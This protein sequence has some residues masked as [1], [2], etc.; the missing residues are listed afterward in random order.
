MHGHA[1]SVRVL[2]GVSHSVS[3]RDY[4]IN[5]I[6]LVNMYIWLSSFLL[7]GE[8]NQLP[9]TSTSIQGLIVG[10]TKYIFCARQFGLA[11]QLVEETA[12]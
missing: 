12:N 9:S 10:G 7:S 6:S 4:Y 1:E 8:I 3:M 11:K 5:V 2:L